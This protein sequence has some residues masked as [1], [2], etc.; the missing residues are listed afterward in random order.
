MTNYKENLMQNFIS[1]VSKNWS[2]REEFCMWHFLKSKFKKKWVGSNKRA[3]R[4][5]FQLI[6]NGQALIRTGRLEFFLKI[7]K[8]ACP[9]IK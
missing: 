9:F 7:N 4:I 1:I 8:R 2:C 3:G 6:I 5:F